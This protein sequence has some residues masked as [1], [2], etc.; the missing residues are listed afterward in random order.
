MSSKE[1]LLITEGIVLNYTILARVEGLITLVTELQQWILD[2][3]LSL[4]LLL[5]ND[6]LRLKIDFHGSYIV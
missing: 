1:Q 5:M 4:S 6:S 2:I 3:S